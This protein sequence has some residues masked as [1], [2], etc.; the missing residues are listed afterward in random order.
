MFTKP[1][2]RPR[3]PQPKEAMP[4]SFAASIVKSP[5][6]PPPPPPAIV[7]K[8]PLLPLLN[9]L[10]SPSSFP[11]QEL[12]SSR[13]NRHQK[14]PLPS[15]NKDHK[16]TGNVTDDDSDDDGSSDYSSSLEDD[17][18]NH[19]RLEDEYYAATTENEKFGISK[20]YYDSIHLPKA[21]ATSTNE[22]L[23]SGSFSESILQNI[24]TN[25]NHNNSTTFLT[26]SCLLPTH[27][28]V[29]NKNSLVNNN[30][31]M[32]EQQ[33]QS[34]TSQRNKPTNAP[35]SI[36]PKWRQSL[37]PVVL[38]E[39]DA[40]STSTTDVLRATTEK[41]LVPIPSKSQEPSP[42]IEQ[43]HEEEDEKESTRRSESQRNT[44]EVE[45][46]DK[47]SSYEHYKEWKNRYSLYKDCESS[48]SS[49]EESLHELLNPSSAPPKTR[50]DKVI[51]NMAEVTS[52]TGGLS[53]ATS[54]H[55]E[56]KENLKSSQLKPQTEMNETKH[57]GGNNSISDRCPRGSI[58]VP[59]TQL[60]GNRNTDN[61]SN[62][63]T[64]HMKVQLPP[65]P[66]PPKSVLEEELKSRLNVILTLKDL[67]VNQSKTMK[68]YITENRKLHSK[69]SSTLKKN[70]HIQQES[71]RKQG[72]IDELE[73]E[74]KQVRLE[75]LE[76]LKHKK[77]LKDDQKRKRRSRR[78]SRRKPI[79]PLLP[80]LQHN[81]KQDKGVGVRLLDELSA[82]KGYTTTT[83]ISTNSVDMFQSNASNEEENHDLLY[84]PMDM[85][86]TTSMKDINSPT[87]TTTTTPT[88]ANTT[89]TT[90]SSSPK[91]RDF[92]YPH[93]Q[94]GCGSTDGGHTSSSST[95][96]TYTTP[97]RKTF[98]DSSHIPY[99][100]PMNTTT[101]ITESATTLTNAKSTVSSILWKLMWQKQERLEELSHEGGND[102]NYYLQP[103]QQRDQ[104]FT[105][106]VFFQDNDD[107]ELAS[108]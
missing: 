81:P 39:E 25:D 18:S 2:P 79:L 8:L 87:G 12:R 54:F 10:S 95:T 69:L 20:S 73:S 64:P 48:L 19:H 7:P 13:T 35:N 102:K 26:S 43:D 59:N 17:N 46:E 16:R 1:K 11:T 28:T 33:Q 106:N 23:T 5:S 52:T 40:T 27:A 14:T 107:F 85:T 44:K 22:T 105:S 96:T 80:P 90:L 84:D 4:G 101:N 55:K 61:Q 98:V 38:E 108:F 71:K 51:K 86:I 53:S 70:T 57:N 9:A 91:F 74:L 6:S 49:L 15:N 41:C 68:S 3:R 97:I 93:Y 89:M 77:Q 24:T 72:R 100:H 103:R 31:S 30:V 63:S 62:N 47:M 99:T 83:T 76:E 36:E 66:S 29:E 34:T 65:P 37:L 75:L 67:V 58:A 32:I 60:N 92:S 42:E 82:T 94:G 88:V 56:L 50:G 104:F 78:S 21:V 45:K